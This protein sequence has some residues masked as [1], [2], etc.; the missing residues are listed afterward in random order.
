MVP[1]ITNMETSYM[2][3][4]KQLIGVSQELIRALKG[5][6]K[7]RMS[8]NSA[9][10]YINIMSKHLY[11]VTYLTLITATYETLEGKRQVQTH[12][13]M[14]AT[15]AQSIH[16]TNVRSQRVKNAKNAPY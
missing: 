6:N 7:L 9:S 1:Y 10:T 2:F 3:L 16:Q 11:A 14:H 12:L 8:Y 13:I 5:L 15:L 4:H